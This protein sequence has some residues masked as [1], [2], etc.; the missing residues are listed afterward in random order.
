MLIE[1]DLGGSFRRVNQSE[2][3]REPLKIFPAGTISVIRLCSLPEVNP[4]AHGII[5]E[6]ALGL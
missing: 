4:F 1:G 6:N 2:F 3:E 5:F